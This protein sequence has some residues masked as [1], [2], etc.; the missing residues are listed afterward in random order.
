MTDPARLEP[1]EELAALWAPGSAVLCTGAGE[2]DVESVATW[3]VSPVGD[4]TG[5]WIVPAG[6]AVDSQEAARRILCLVER[7]AIAAVHPQ[8]L[9]EWLERLTTTAKVSAGSSA[10]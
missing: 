2:H 1:L 4:P 6:E 7:R 8:N 9:Q 5:A 10:T 3:H